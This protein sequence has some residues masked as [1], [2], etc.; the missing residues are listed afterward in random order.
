MTAIVAV[1]CSGANDPDVLQITRP[2]STAKVPGLPG[3]PTAPAAV[4]MVAVTLDSASLTVGHATAAH[5]VAKDAAGNVIT[6]R[7]VTWS[8]SSP[9]TA[10]VAS[11]MVT[12]KK[13]GTA[14][15]SAKIDE[16]TGSATITVPVSPKG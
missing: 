13:A 8:S 2:D 12:A 15:I 5:A 16:V 10:S 7:T 1:A 4:A 14:S 6:G 11:G 9:A 3:T